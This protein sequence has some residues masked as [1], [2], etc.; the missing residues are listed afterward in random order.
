MKPARETR[1]QTEGFL[2]VIMS[3]Q[4]LR[5]PKRLTFEDRQLVWNQG[6]HRFGDKSQSRHGIS[7]RE[8]NLMP[9]C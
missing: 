3:F 5:A 9:E 2:V 1:K 8:R 4:W 6:D 7:N